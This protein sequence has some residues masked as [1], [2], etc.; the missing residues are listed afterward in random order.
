MGTSSNLY[1]L[2]SADE[3]YTGD[4]SM[5]VKPVIN[6]DGNLGSWVSVWNLDSQGLTG[7]MGPQELP[8]AVG[9]RTEMCQKPAFTESIRSIGSQVLPE[10]AGSHRE[11]RRLQELAW[12]W[13]RP[14]LIYMVKLTA[15]FILLFPLGR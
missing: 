5:V 4:Q 3:P 7:S 8:R 11:H 1:R 15:Y 9:A 13:G 10:F 6:P 2:A 14:T 12:C